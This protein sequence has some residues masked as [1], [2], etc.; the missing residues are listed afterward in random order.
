[1]NTVRKPEPLL[2]FDMHPAWGSIP[3]VEV[4]SAI[5]CDRVTAHLQQLDLPKI[6]RVQDI[7]PRRQRLGNLQQM[8]I[9]Q[10]PIRLPTHIDSCLVPATDRGN[11]NSPP[12]GAYMKGDGYVDHHVV[13]W[14]MI[15]VLTP[16]HETNRLKPNQY[17]A[18]SQIDPNN[19]DCKRSRLLKSDRHPMTQG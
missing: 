16:C 7:H 3:L 5:E 14:S 15:G 10:R 12:Q 19:D 13:F 9:G 2:L 6:L 4:H 8:A 17:R 18:R 1:M 11:S